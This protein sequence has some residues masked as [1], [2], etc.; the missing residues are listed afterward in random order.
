MLRIRPARPAEPTFAFFPH[1]GATALSIG[2]LLTALPPQAGVAV[3]DLPRGGGLDDGTPPRQAAAAAQALAQGL[4]ALFEQDARAP[5]LVLVG[6]SYGALLAYE[7]A[8]HLLDTA[9]SPE[10]LVVSGFRA[11]VLPPADPPLYRL[12][13]PQLRAELSARYGG[14]HD[15]GGS[16]WGGELGAEAL[17][18][19]L[20]ACDT[21]RHARAGR[22]PLPID[23]LRLTRDTST[24]LE[25]LRAWQSVTDR[26]L[27]MADCAAG[28][29]PWAEAPELIARTLVHLTQAT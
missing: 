16:A 10:R 27:R 5:R 12:P 28:H 3:A 11:P 19:D 18:A 14:P 17:R 8:W 2:R 13:L 4:A 9:L 21:Y 24:P 29:F 20:Q 15:D 25:D 23:V 22:L 6:N 1:A 7:T 26:P